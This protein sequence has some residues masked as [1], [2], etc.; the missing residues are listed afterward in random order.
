MTTARE[1]YAHATSGT[2][3]YS[4]GTVTV[5]AMTLTSISNVDGVTSS[6]IRITTIP[7]SKDI[8]PVRNQILEIDFL[9]TTIAG[10]VDTV[11][12]G[13]TGAG[14]TYTTTASYTTTKSY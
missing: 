6:R 11:A 3:N 10:E 9:N 12:V 13:D 7:S 2:V 5:N 14:S 8:V 4:T 1:I